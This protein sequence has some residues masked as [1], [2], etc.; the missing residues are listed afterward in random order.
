MSIFNG[1]HD[2]GPKALLRVSPELEEDKV[3]EAFTLCSEKWPYGGLNNKEFEIAVKYL[4]VKHRYSHTEET[5]QDVL[6]RKPDRCVALLNGHF[7]AILDGEVAG[8]EILF[9][10][11]SKTKVFC[12]WTFH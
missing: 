10:S 7:I 3:K 1:M 11:P 5:L 12:S 6:D 2:C 9:G 4:D 8:R